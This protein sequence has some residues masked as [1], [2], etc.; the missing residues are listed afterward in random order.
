RAMSDIESMLRRIDPTRNAVVARTK[1]SPGE[2]AAA[3]DGAVWLSHSSEDT[4]SRIDPAT[5]KVSA[6]IHVGPQPTGLAVSPAAVWAADAG[7]PSVSRIHP[8]TNQRVA[9]TRVCPKLACCSEPMSLS[10]FPGSLPVAAAHATT[11]IRL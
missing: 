8:A 11:P 1:V 9:T 4:V 5:N 6:T 7:G 10:A 2:A 3:G